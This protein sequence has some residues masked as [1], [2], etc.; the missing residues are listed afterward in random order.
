MADIGRETCQEGTLWPRA[1]KPKGYEPG[2]MLQEIAP[3]R[4]IFVPWN[5]TGVVVPPS[6]DGRLRCSRQRRHH[7]GGAKA[8]RPCFCRDLRYYTARRNV[9]TH[10][11]PG[12]AREPT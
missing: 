1:D 10:G 11:P 4:R 3:V 6:R 12:K 2:V 5:G 9:I 7:R 8:R